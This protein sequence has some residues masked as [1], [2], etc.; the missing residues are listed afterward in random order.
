MVKQKYG[1][2]A[3]TYEKKSP[4]GLYRL[5]KEQI[6]VLAAIASLL[7]KNQMTPVSTYQKFQ[8]VGDLFINFVMQY[9]QTQILKS[10]VFYIKIN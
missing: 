7:K 9:K 5:K 2:I 1:I 3:L 6:S 10:S 8:N 4:T